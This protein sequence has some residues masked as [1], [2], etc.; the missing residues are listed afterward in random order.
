MYEEPIGRPRVTGGVKDSSKRRC[1]SVF[2]KFL[3][4]AAKNGVGDFRPVDAHA[5]NRY[6]VNLEKKDYAQKTLFH[7]L[8]TL[9]Q[10]APFANERSL[11]RRIATWTANP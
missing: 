8:T 9:K 5:L 1:R 11:S 6:A 4:W 3:A 7:E 10:C 2:D